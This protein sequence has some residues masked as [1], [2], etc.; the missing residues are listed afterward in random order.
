MIKERW[1]VNWFMETSKEGGE[2]F[3]Y[4]PDFG[5]T[6]D[7][8]FNL[9]ALADDLNRKLGNKPELLKEE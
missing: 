6:I 1:I 3:H 2:Y 9:Q 4:D 7:G 5:S 8:T